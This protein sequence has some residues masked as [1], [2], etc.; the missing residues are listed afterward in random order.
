LPV[1]RLIVMLDDAE[2]VTGPDSSTTRTLARLVR[3]RLRREGPEARPTRKEGE[4]CPA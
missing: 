3:E 2:R 1:W 4:P